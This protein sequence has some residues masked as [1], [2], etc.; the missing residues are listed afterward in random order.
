MISK[1]AKDFI[2]DLPGVSQET[3]T[4]KIDKNWFPYTKIELEGTEDVFLIDAKVLPKGS[5]FD[6]DKWV[7]LMREQPMQ[8]VKSKPSLEEAI[9]VLCNELED[10]SYFNSWSLDISESFISEYFKL[11]NKEAFS[12]QELKELI[13]IANNA[14]DKFLK[15]LMG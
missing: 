2:N 7:K 12:P 1:Q 3:F 13:D 5:D 6:I 11:Y 9:E 8:I 4:I 10:E 15:Q 14:A